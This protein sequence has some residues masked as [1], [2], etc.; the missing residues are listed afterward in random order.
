MLS[1]IFTGKNHFD[2]KALLPQHPTSSLAP[3]PPPPLPPGTDYVILEQPVLDY[4]TH[5]EKFVLIDA[6][7]E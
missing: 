2:N 1:W 6:N 3:L 7:R 4:P 5:L